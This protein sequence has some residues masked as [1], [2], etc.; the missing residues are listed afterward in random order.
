MRFRQVHLDF[1]T[2]GDIPGVGSAFVPE[3]FQRTLLESAVDSITCFAVCHH[4]YCYYPSKVG[5]RHP[6]LAFDLLRAQM[7]A[8]HEVGIQ[9]PVY[10]SVGGNE[11]SW[12]G[13]PEWREIYPEGMTGW[14]GTGN[15]PLF[16]K[17]CLN[18]SYLDYFCKLLEE[19]LLRFPDADGLFFDIV[20]QGECVC[21][22]CQKGMLE[23]KL[24]PTRAADRQA[25][26]TMV[27]ERYYR[28]I[29]ELRLRLAPN[30]P[31][32]HNSCHVNPHYPQFVKFY[33]H[34]ELESLPTGGWG[35]DH[36]PL[37]AAYARKTNLQ[38]SGMT[39]KFHRSWGEFGGLKTPQALRY[40]CAA[41]MANG[42]KC[43][44][45][46]QCHP[47][48]RLDDS[49]YAVIG[50]VY[51]EVR[52][53]EPFCATAA[54]RAEI[55]LLLKD[56]HSPAAIG[57]SRLLL[58]GHCLFDVLRPDMDYS[59]Y[60]MAI[61]PETVSLSDDEKARLMRFAEH[62]GKVL[63]VGDAISGLPLDFGADC[64]GE[65]PMF[66]VYLLPAKRYRPD[67][68]NTP[69]VCLAK[70]MMMKATAG[71]SL[72]ELYFPYFN[73]TPEHF[74][75]HQFT[76]NRL[77]PSGF[78]AG[79]ALRNCAALALPLFSN[80][81]E[82]GMVLLKD[83]AVR[84]VDHLLGADRIVRSNLPS[85]AR[86]TVTEDAENGRQVVHLL[87][88]NLLKRG[89]GLEVIDELLPLHDVELSVHAGGR[90]IRCVRLQPQGREIPFQQQAGRVD[91][92]VERFVCHQMVVLEWR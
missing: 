13:H 10:L 19:V 28:R 57:A 88:A 24:D 11:L 87:Y 23:Q 12:K 51:R 41:M 44:I 75:G 92:R 50:K 71:D 72:G 9:V 82:E 60:P 73:R 21:P 4:G 76:P 40:E 42:A 74:S 8:A 67:F 62:G 36:F 35:Y 89:D 15:P 78:T 30:M 33:T 77:E 29:E 31:V 47:A 49:T 90:N 61:L 18:T 2:G 54:N 20:F 53:K 64:L 70:C 80:Y 83:F 48:G 37:T 43:S 46:D 5:V 1:H 79:T 85:M 17:L 39:G 32:F 55:A 45:G 68:L 91:F 65:C 16:H 34:W 66:P 81:A 63:A 26:G 14:G 59:A 86:V 6:T 69:L 25:Y 52:E 84:V 38:F 3:E 27:M 56:L 58:E 7:D 22:E